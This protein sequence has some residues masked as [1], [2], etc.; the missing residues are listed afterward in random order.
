M[1]RATVAILTW[2]APK[3]LQRTLASLAPIAG[4]FAE[5]LVV[6][7][8][9]HAEEMALAER[10]GFKAVGTAENLGVQGGL[11]R[12]VEAASSPA[13]LVL[14]NDNLYCGGDA[15]VADLEAALTLMAERRPFCIRLNQVIRNHKYRTFWGGGYP[16]RRTLAAMLRPRV[17]RTYLA[18]ALYQDN[19]DPAGELPFLE[20]VGE[21]IWLTD[22]RY[23]PWSN[24]AFLVWRDRFLGE[25]IAFANSHPTS[26]L[27]N[28]R[29]GL[30]SQ[31][32]H[33]KNRWWWR[34]QQFPIAICAPGLFGHRRHDRDP[35]D[36]KWLIGSPVE[37]V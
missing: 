30:E 16:P 4:L 21:R 11:Q 18:Y 32:N 7:Q 10:Y 23:L 22:S 27:V 9:S 35:N 8:E 34:E 12:C 6:C 20:R 28:G 17:A 3:T 37:T 29:P 15:G 36:E 13:V 26:K 31:I 25:L 2:N 33:P 14:E 19:F 1:Q 5:R 24:R